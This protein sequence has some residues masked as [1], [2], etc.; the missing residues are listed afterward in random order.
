MSERD[1][2]VWGLL[3]AWSSG[4]RWFPTD[5][6]FQADVGK[7]ITV[8]AGS[9]ETEAVSKITWLGRQALAEMPEWKGIE[10]LRS[11]FV[12]HFPMPPGVEQYNPERGT[13]YLDGPSDARAIAATQ[14]PK[15]L[16][17][18]GDEPFDADAMLAECR[19]AMEESRVN[20]PNLK[21]HGR[22]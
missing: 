7:R 21:H 11:I 22:R 6:D 10:A 15:Q 14:A 4:M 5:P 13:Y 3:E 19:R 9:E 2:A 18:P 16:Q 12:G 1:A 8:W 17:A 20:A